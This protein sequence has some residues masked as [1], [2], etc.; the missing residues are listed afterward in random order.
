V[1]MYKNVLSSIPG[2]E[3][4][5]IVALVIFFAFFIGLIVWYIRVDRGALDAIAQMPFE[6]GESTSTDLHASQHTARS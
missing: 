2:I 1:I 5:P 6:D 4:Y 3:Y